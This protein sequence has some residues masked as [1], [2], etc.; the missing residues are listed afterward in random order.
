MDVRYAEGRSDRYPS[1]VAELIGLKVDLIVAG[2]SPDAAKKLTSTIP[3]VMPAV[4]EVER[5]TVLG[6]SIPTQTQELADAMESAA[7]ALGIR[8]QV[9][10]ASRVEEL[11]GTFR[12][13]TNGRAETLIVLASAG[14][15]A[16]H[17]R[18]IE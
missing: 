10:T 13:A 3:I 17:R 7:R 5:V 2:G 1:M 9:L 8:L 6:S 12:V 14:F 16:N 18:M 4:T 11:E 15:T